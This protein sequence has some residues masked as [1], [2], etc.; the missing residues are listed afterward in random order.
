MNKKFIVSLETAKRLKELRFSQ[1]TDFYWRR[2]AAD[3]WGNYDLLSRE[4][5]KDS[6][7]DDVAAP[8]VGELGEWC[9]WQHLSIAQ[10]PKYLDF[11]DGKNTEAE[12]RG[13]WLIYLAENNF[14]NNK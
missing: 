10:P 3:A 2:V 4:T 14:L 9:K 12:A 11:I 1:E 8:H 5:N 13:L 6:L 7:V